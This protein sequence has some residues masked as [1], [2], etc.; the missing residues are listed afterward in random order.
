MQLRA[1][2]SEDERA[3]WWSGARGEGLPFIES[4]PALGRNVTIRHVSLI[5]LIKTHPSQ[6]LLLLAC[7]FLSVPK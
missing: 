6:S 2:L 5:P 1:R 4:P 3:E 7:T